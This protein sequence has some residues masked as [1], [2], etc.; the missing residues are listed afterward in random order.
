MTSPPAWCRHRW[1]EQ[2]GPGWAG[3]GGWA[4]GR[5]CY[6]LKTL[7]PPGGYPYPRP[8]PP[9]GHSHPQE[10][11]SAQQ[12]HCGQEGLSV[13]IYSTGHSPVGWGAS[14][15]S[16]Q[17]RTCGPASCSPGCL[18]YHWWRT[19]TSGR[20]ASLVRGVSGPGR[21]G[22]SGGSPRL[23]PAGELQELDSRLC[24][25]CVWGWKE[26]GGD[27]AG[28][29]VG[30]GLASPFL[31]TGRPT[32]LMLQLLGAEAHPPGAPRAMLEPHRGPWG[33]T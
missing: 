6:S 18:Q 33:M 32:L 17:G 1:A 29:G 9:H 25:V 2:V 27:P 11:T 5:R 15:S 31:D 28:K 23:Q 20:P 22:G 21:H 14:R 24:L 7:L 3:G 26:A 10:D 30:L 13:H 16:S 19:G 8:S 12:R 4:A